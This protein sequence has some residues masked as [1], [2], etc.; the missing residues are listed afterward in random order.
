[1]GEM[2]FENVNGV[3][4]NEERCH[5]YIIIELEIS[6]QHFTVT[7]GSTFCL[8]TIFFKFWSSRQLKSRGRVL[9]SNSTRTWVKINIG[10]FG[11]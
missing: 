7:A 1:M 5:V 11:F 6:P 2:V 10:G 9:W 4:G 8:G 3:H